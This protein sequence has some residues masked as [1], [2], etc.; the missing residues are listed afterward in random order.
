VLLLLLLRAPDELLRRWSVRVRID[1]HI[2][3]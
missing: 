1:D 3:I 2:L